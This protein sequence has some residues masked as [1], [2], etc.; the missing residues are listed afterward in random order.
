MPEAAVKASL[1]ASNNL[2]QSVAGRFRE[3][4]L[5]IK[6]NRCLNG[7]PGYVEWPV[8]HPVDTIAEI[9]LCLSGQSE[10]VFERT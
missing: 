5:V 3:F 9:Y 4:A 1:E 6:A 2:N 7:T 10:G 8:N